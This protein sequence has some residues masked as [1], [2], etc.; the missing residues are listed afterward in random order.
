M[1]PIGGWDPRQP[2]LLYREMDR[3][4]SGHIYAKAAIDYAVWDIPAQ[5]AGLP[6]HGV[7][8]GLESAAVPLISS[9]HVD[10]PTAMVDNVQRWR[11]QGYRRHS[12]KVGEGVD[13]DI[14]RV[15]HLAAA[16]EPDEVF[17][18]DANGGWFDAN[19]G[20]SPWEAVRV[21]NAVADTDA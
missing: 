19:G 7:L 16:R 6:L 21:L 15:R 13:A 1:P 18:F 8:G 20:W 11:D 3:L 2:E 14:A 4:L 9:I 10:S 5:A 17:I 12:V